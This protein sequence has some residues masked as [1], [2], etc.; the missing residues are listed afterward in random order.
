ME[1]AKPNRSRRVVDMI[2][3]A[4]AGVFVMAEVSLY[5]PKTEAINQW[6]ERIVGKFRAHRA[7][8]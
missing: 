3:N 6:F 5:W 2:A 1:S 4:K 7:L 8:F